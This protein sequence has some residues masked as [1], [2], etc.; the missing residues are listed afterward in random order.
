L[1][2]LGLRLVHVNWTTRTVTVEGVQDSEFAKSL[3]KLASE[4]T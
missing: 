4:T 2:R 3:A 1:E